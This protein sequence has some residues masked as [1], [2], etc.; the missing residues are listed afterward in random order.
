[1]HS[2]RDGLAAIGIQMIFTVVFL[3]VLL[4]KEGKP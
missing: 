1:V 3:S 2:P 4:L